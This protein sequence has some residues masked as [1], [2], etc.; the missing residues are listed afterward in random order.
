MRQVFI[1]YR[2]E[3][4]EHVREVR[5]LGEV[6]RDSGLQVAL[7]QFVPHGP[8]QGWTKWCEDCANES[9]AVLVVASAGWFAA[10]SGVDPPDMGLGA[11]TE[12]NLFRQEFYEKKGSSERIRLVSLHE[13]PRHQVPRLLRSVH[14]FR[15]FQND[16]DLNQL[17]DW[18]ADRLGLVGIKPP[19]VQWPQP[20]PFDRDMAD[21][22][23]QEWPALV[24]LLAGGSRERILFFEGG[25]NL[26]KSYLIRQA[27]A[28]ARTLGIPVCHVDFKGSIRDETA[29]LRQFYL[30]LSE[31]LP[32]F[33]QDLKTY[34]LRS[35]LRALRRPVL[36]IFD[37]YEAAADN[38]P[39]A[40]W[41]SQ[42]LLSEVETALGL[43]VIVA[44]QRVPPHSDTA[45]RDLA[46]HIRLQPITEIEHW[47]PWLERRFPGIDYAPHL[48]TLLLAKANPGVIA[49]LCKG[50]AESST[51]KPSGVNYDA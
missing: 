33:K 48:P 31:E 41:L 47:M 32:S 49:T 14:C 20:R 28:Y 37:T 3:S 11:A 38:N 51:G 42:Q 9:A 44:G 35:D 23:R 45:W 34:K 12:A 25:S 29:I 8:D 27:G 1:S 30:D 2:H 13:V 26:G 24:E 21:R 36:I 5:R 7:D 50:I 40:E 19:T 4:P 10:Y 17:V 16:T 6:L 15:P 18:I 39:V 46:R 22:D 43:A